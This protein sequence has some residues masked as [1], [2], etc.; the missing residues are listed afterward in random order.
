MKIL[1]A[2]DDPI[3]RMLLT[4]TLGQ[5]GHTV[6]P[7]ADG[8]EAWAA[9]QQGDHSILITDYLMPRIDGFE[10]ARR[11]RAR[12]PGPYLYL[13]LL[14]TEGSKASLLSAIQA[15]VD[16]FIAKPFDPEL[17]NA[18]LHVA[19]RILGLRQ[20]IHHLEGL[21]PV[22]AWCKKMR[23]EQGNWEVMETYL[24][25]HS[26]VRLTHGMCPEC[27]RSFVS[28]ATHRSP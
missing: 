25:R 16:D 5:Q 28:E 2:E 3:A 18:R 19:E 7:T 15:G 1:V 9:I 22:C 12:P 26:Q 14:T 17:L 13:I 24:V 8:E 11:V 27:Q 20:H 23:D 4:A 6:C 21:L 10:L